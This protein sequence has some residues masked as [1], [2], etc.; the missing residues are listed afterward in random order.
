MR[1][2]ASRPRRASRRRDA[3]DVAWSYLYEDDDALLRGMLSAGGVGDAA[4]PAHEPELRAGLLEALAPFR[5][6]RGGYRLENEWHTL[7][8]TA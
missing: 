5:T 1:S 2:K 8:A 4:G 7:V 6:A 3:F